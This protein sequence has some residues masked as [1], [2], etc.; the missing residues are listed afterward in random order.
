MRAPRA[1]ASTIFSNIKTLC[2]QH[3]AECPRDES[4]RNRSR[5]EQRLEQEDPLAT[6]ALLE[7]NPNG[8]EHGHTRASRSRADRRLG[9]SE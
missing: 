3:S 4:C 2:L 1:I 7:L 9:S 5:E 8:V 6:L